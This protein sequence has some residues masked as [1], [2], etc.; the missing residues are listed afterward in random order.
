MIHLSTPKVTQVTKIPGLKFPVEKVSQPIHCEKK[1]DLSVLG[2]T[3]WEGNLL[4]ALTTVKE[5]LEVLAWAHY[6][7]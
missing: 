2:Q 6:F 7:P 3:A 1:R 4:A 5:W